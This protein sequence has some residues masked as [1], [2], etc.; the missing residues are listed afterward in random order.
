[1][2]GRTLNQLSELVLK[3]FYGGQTRTIDQKVTKAQVRI[4]L[5]Q[6]RDNLIK[7]MLEQDLKKGGTPDDTFFTRY[8]KHPVLYDEDREMPYIELPDG[9]LDLPHSAG[10]R[11]SP[12]NGYVNPFIPAPSGYFNARRELASLEGNIGWQTAPSTVNG[13]EIVEFP[14]MRQDDFKVV[15]LDVI[16]TGGE[17]KPDE[18]LKMPSTYEEDCIKKVL[19]LLGYNRN[20]DEAND[21]RDQV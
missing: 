5:I 11:I 13:A 6:A 20:S 3:R 19:D 12:T 7:Q 1:M 18:P 16:T 15:N 2:A 9:Y 4:H 21:N 8:K 14:T 17:N 10:V